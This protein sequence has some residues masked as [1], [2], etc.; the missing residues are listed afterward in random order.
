MMEI[1]HFLYEEIFFSPLFYTLIIFIIEIHG[2]FKRSIIERCANVYENKKEDLV[3][4]KTK[5]FVI[6]WLPRWLNGKESTCQCRRCRRYVF[7]LWVGKIPWGR[8]W[9]ATPLFLPG[10]FHGQRS[11]VGYSPRGHKELDMT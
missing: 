4:Q 11:L 8:K 2:L 10:K 9:K 3:L 5:L 7:D 6:K 1:S